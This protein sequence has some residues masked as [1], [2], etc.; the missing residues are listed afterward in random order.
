MILRK[1]KF[2]TH[3]TYHHITVCKL[4]MLKSTIEASSTWLLSNW[5]QEEEN[6]K[7]ELVSSAYQE[8]SSANWLPLEFN[9]QHIT[10]LGQITHS[11]STR[12]NEKSSRLY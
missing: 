1:S 4:N 2:G 10:Q 12:L 6:W 3:T 11:F 9:Y 7:F 8:W 5:P